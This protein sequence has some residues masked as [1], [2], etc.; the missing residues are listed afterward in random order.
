MSL[1]ARSE[2]PERVE[3]PAS[4]ER[5]DRVASVERPERSRPERVTR[6]DLT[7]RRLRIDRAEGLLQSARDA[8]DG[9]QMDAWAARCDE[10][11]HSNSVGRS[12]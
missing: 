4:P 10:L 7:D 3:R 2:R 6:A 5:L 9:L 8:Y 12:A 1:A 11:G